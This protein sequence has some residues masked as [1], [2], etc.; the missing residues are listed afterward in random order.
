MTDLQSLPLLQDC[1]GSCEHDRAMY[2]IIVP[3]FTFRNCWWRYSIWVAD[4][5]EN[6]LDS[7]VQTSAEVS[8]LATCG[9]IVDEIKCSK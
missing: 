1:Q 2:V 8:G 7:V 3:C 6:K 4:L 5:S 9:R